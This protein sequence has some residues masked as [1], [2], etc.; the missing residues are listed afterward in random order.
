MKKIS[1]T[2]TRYTHGILTAQTFAR[3]IQHLADVDKIA[4]DN[5]TFAAMSRWKLVDEHKV[6]E[7]RAILTPLWSIAARP[8]H[9]SE[10]D[11][12]IEGISPDNRH[13]FK[14]MF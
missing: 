4:R 6:A 7:L 2:T 5:E 8:N 10:Y 12:F 14:R 3:P 11:K 1:A 13:G 9:L